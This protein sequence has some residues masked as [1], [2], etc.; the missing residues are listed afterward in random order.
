MKTQFEILLRSGKL[1]AFETADLALTEAGIPHNLQEETASG[2]RTAMPIDPSPGP[3]V[4]WVILVPDNCLSDAQDV[5]A[6]LPFDYTTN[7]DVW[8]CEPSPRG[9]KIIQIGAWISIGAIV[10]IFIV[11]V[12][13]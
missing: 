12:L 5:I 1:H 13:N 3:G 10:L 4:W 11:N 2:M 8:D 9:K 7:P 6:K